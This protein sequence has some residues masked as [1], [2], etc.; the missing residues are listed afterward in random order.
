MPLDVSLDSELDAVVIRATGVVSSAELQ[1]AVGD[2][3]ILAGFEPGMNQL[4]DVSEGGLDLDASNLRELAE[5]FQ[6][7]GVRKRLGTGYKLAI[8]AG[9]AVDFGVARMY[10]VFNT[11]DAISIQ[12]FYTLKDARIWLREP[13]GPSSTRA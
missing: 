4:F 11:E 6:A 1:L 3:L 12:V 7:P 9:R 8:V 5:F 2:V 10:E 13:R